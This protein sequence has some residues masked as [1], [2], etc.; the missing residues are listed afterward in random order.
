[1][2]Y[3]I[4]MSLLYL[5]NLVKEKKI[6]FTFPLIIVLIVKGGL[7]DPYTTV[8]YLAYESEY[9][10]KYLGFVSR[11]EW[12]YQDISSWAVKNYLTYSQF[13]VCLITGTFIILF[14]AVRRLTKNDK[15]FG[16][17]LRYFLF[18]LKQFRYVRLQ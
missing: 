4:N 8:D 5:F 11:F 10:N 9:N 14:V 12:L 18:S 7:P 15:F 1:M 3:I 16:Y 13:R 2:L 17:C 6:W